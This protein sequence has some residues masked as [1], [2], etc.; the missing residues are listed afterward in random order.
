MFVPHAFF[1]STDGIRKTESPPSL[2]L[3][4]GYWKYFGQF[5]DYAKRLSYIGRS[6]NF[7]A[8]AA[9]YFPVKTAWAEFRPLYRFFLHEL[10]EKKRKNAYGDRKIRV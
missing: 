4:N 3:Q 7:V 8:D 1:Y 6:G 2:F 9:I 10:D 5:S